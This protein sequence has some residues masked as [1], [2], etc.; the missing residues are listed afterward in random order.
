MK[1]FSIIAFAIFGIS[2]GFVLKEA[3]IIE[4]EISQH[5]VESV[6]F[7]SDKFKRS[8]TSTL[9][10]IPE[11]PIIKSSSEKQPSVQLPSV[12]R[13]DSKQTPVSVEQSAASSDIVILATAAVTTQTIATST[14]S[15]MLIHIRTCPEGQEMDMNRVCRDLFK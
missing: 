3:K 11:S 9:S 6:V 15:R 1:F 2:A 8:A 10:S 7:S 5:V 13:I 14:S 12:V 4:G